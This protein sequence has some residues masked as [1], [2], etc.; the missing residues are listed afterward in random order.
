LKFSILRNEANIKEHEIKL[1][2]LLFEYMLPLL[3][4]WLLQEKPDSEKAIECSSD[5]DYNDGWNK[6][7]VAL[8][9][10]VIYGFKVVILFSSSFCAGCTQST[11]IS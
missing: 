1:Y 9:I 3:C 4:T 8:C 5:L 7:Q 2:S 11:W 6:S 10:V